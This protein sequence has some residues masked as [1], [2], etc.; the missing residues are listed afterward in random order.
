MSRPSAQRLGWLALYFAAALLPRFQSLTHGVVFAD[1]L[2]H[3]PRGHLESYRFLNYVELWLWQ[4]V[5]GPRYLLTA[6][7]KVVGSIYTALLCLTVRRSLLAWGAPLAL[8]AVLPLFIPLHPIWTTFIVANAATPYVLS[9]LLIVCGY[10]IVSTRSGLG[11]LA[12]AGVLIAAG[13]SGYQ[14]HIGLIPALLFAEFVLRGLAP[15]P[16]ARRLAATAAGVA[17]YAVACAIAAALGVET[18]GGRGVSLQVLNAARVTAAV[19]AITDNIAIVTQ[20]VL[21]FYG[22]VVASWRA[23]MVPFFA[24]ALL[25]AV[26]ARRKMFA[27]APFLVPVCAAFPIVPLNELP[28]GPRVAAAIWIAAVIS[29]LPLLLRASPR[30]LA[31]IVVAASIVIVPVIVADCINGVNAWNDDRAAVSAISAYWDWAGVPREQIV[32]TVERA[33]TPGDPAAWPSRPIVL[34]NFH[35][36]TSWD[37]SNLQLHPDWLFEAYGFRYHPSPPRSWKASAHSIAAEWMHD[38]SGRRTLVRI[39]RRP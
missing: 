22:G 25:T 2:V 6:I 26:L 21:S 32:V 19:H 3:R 31:I 28:T 33:L 34:Q 14:V 4:H 8:A 38:P 23:W 5:F 17:I 20:P 30:S 9:L 10:L 39:A 36:V 7:P 1:D 18:W 35:P 11:T 27:L 12:A 16:L 29:T 15:R 37:Y 13:I 24:L